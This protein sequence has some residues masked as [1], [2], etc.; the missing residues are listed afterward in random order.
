MASKIIETYIETISTHTVWNVWIKL[1]QLHSPGIRCHQDVFLTVLLYFVSML[2]EF[3]STGL[4]WKSPSERAWPCHSRAHLWP[5]CWC[6]LLLVRWWE[7]CWHMHATY[8]HIYIYVNVYIY[9]HI[10]IYIIHN[11]I[12]TIICLDESNSI[13][14]I[15]SLNL[16]FKAR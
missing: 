15:H 3:N 16:V 9:N 1:N 10:Y 11:Y 12:H 5:H 2:S 7:L 8:I 14:M 6:R 13:L 4:A